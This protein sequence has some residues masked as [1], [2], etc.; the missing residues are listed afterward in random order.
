VAWFAL[1]LTLVVIAEMNVPAHTNKCIARHNITQL[2]NVDAVLASPKELLCRW[3]VRTKIGSLDDE[4]GDKAYGVTSHYFIFF[5]FFVSAI[6]GS[7]DQIQRDVLEV[8]YLL[9]FAITILAQLLVNT[10]LVRERFGN[11][12]TFS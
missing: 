11:S 5:L 2:W 7:G 12:A 4:M 6:L 1:C 10:I 8:S 3:L 9:F